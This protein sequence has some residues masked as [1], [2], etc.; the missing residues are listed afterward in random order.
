MRKNS[1][2][3]T[4]AKGLI[5]QELVRQLIEDKTAN[6][7][8]LDTSKKGSPLSDADSFVGDINHPP[9]SLFE[10]VDTVIHLASVM[11]VEYTDNNPIQTIETIVNGT[12][13]ILEL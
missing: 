10:G 7:K 4:G 12:R 6:L 13:N 1:I 9:E 3:I 2:L 8:T 11:G 5:G